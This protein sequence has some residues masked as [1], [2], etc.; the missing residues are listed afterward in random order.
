MSFSDLGLIFAYLLKSF[1]LKTLFIFPTISKNP[2]FF[3]KNKSTKIS[4]EA[5]IIIGVEGPSFEHFLINLI[6]GK[7][8]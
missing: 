2:I 7:N 8:L 6:D 5:F 3:F 1:C 4:L